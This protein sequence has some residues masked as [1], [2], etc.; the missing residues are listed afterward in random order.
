MCSQSLTCIYF[1]LKKK[2]KSKMFT[3]QRIY[4]RAFYLPYFRPH[5]LSPPHSFMLYYMLGNALLQCVFFGFFFCFKSSFINYNYFVQLDKFKKKSINDMIQILSLFSFLF[6]FLIKKETKK[7]RGKVCCLLA[8]TY[9][10]LTSISIIT[11]NVPVNFF[12]SIYTS[13]IFHD[14][15]ERSCSE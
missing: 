6:F 2:H 14:N 13:H 12:H 10:F 5:I 7:R 8:T 15:S 3:Y 9:F 11:E 4:T 1:F